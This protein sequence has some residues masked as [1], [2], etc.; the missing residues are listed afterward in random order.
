[1]LLWDTLKAVLSKLYTSELAVDWVRAIYLTPSAQVLM[2][3]L[4]SDPFPFLCG[5]RQGCLLSPF[6]FVL[7]LEPLSESIRTNANITSIIA[8]GCAHKLLLYADDI[9]LTL[10]R[11]SSSLLALMEVIERYSK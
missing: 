6:L 3:G 9:L 4:L 2:N 7:V 10:T 5:T 1:R 8:G 11:P